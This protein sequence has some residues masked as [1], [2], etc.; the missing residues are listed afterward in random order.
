M[1]KCKICGQEFEIQRHMAGHIAVV[2]NAYKIRS[3]NEARTLPRQ[4]IIKNCKKCNKAFEVIMR[5]GKD[6][7]LRSA[8]HKSEPEYCKVCAHSIGGSFNKGKKITVVC[9]NCNKEIEVSKNCSLKNFLCLDCHKILRRRTKV[10]AK[11]VENKRYKCTLC[12]KEIP[13]TKY[14]LCKKCLHTSEDYKQL[15]SKR[16]KENMRDGK[17]K[18]WQTRNIL[19]YPEKFFIKVLKNNNLLDRC[20]VNYPIKQRDLGLDNDAN[21]FL[22][23]FFEDKKL[24]LEIDGKQHKYPDRQESDKLRDELLNQHGIK[25]YR[26]RWKNPINTANKTYIKDEIDKFLEKL[27]A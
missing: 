24:D 20:K 25:V 14:G 13:K 9:N 23:F 12:S 7:N 19:S 15:L 21:Y 18:P 10:G 5:I 22:D 8:E 11:K 1:Y 27:N 3:A 17:I 2:H 26:I 4:T 16:A 6:G